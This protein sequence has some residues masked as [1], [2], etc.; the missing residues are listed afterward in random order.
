MED[1][2]YN[3]RCLLRDMVYLL[4]GAVFLAMGL[5]FFLI[6]NKIATGGVAGL[7]IV[8]HY[9]LGFPTGITM[10]VLNI[11]LMLIG[12]IFLGRK[13]LLKTI[14]AIILASFFT[15][16]F[17]INLGF[18]SLT[19]NLML[20]TIYGGLS[21]GVGLGLVFRG[22]A[23]AGGGT[24]LARILSQKTHFKTGQVLFIIDVGVITSAALTFQNIELALWGFLTIFIASQIVDLLL[25]GK[26]FAKVVHIVTGK[27]DEI[28]EHIMN[29]LGRSA[30]IL[31]ARGLF[32]G[33]DRNLIMVVVDA[34][35]VFH[36]RDIVRL[37]DR[38]AFM[39][40]SEAREILG[41]GF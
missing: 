22:D 1:K 14:L 32:S 5:V 13:F 7:A 27:V 11:P 40:V 9:L 34:S 41:K 38:E 4:V 21:V 31:P 39:I 28:G 23:S 24:I 33:E 20:A 6:P 15:D 19:D 18:Q 8:F 12:L 2:K 37:H 36:L 17:S 30:T 26:P 25:T 16:F 35:Q 3:M 10:L 29:D